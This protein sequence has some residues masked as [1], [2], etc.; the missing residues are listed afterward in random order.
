MLSNY[1][2]KWFISTTT[3]TATQWT[4]LFTLT[5]IKL[6]NK[7]QKIMHDNS[8]NT[9]GSNDTY[10]LTTLTHCQIQFN[11]SNNYN[12]NN[13]FKMDQSTNNAEK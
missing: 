5:T 11:N 1:K 12:S 3:I 8:N 13:L 2:L 4:A 7:P 6:N 9:N 10:V